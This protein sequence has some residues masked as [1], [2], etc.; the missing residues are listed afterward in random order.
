MAFLE[1]ANTTQLSNEDDSKLS[2]SHCARIGGSEWFVLSRLSKES[3]GA[4]VV[5]TKSGNGRW[6]RMTRATMGIVD[7]AI[8]S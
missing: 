4:D 2:S 8:H 5:A 6:R 7:A 1:F 3:I